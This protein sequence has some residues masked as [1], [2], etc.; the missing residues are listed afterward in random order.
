MKFFNPQPTK[1]SWAITLNEKTN[2]LEAVDSRKGTF[3]AQLIHF[4]KTGSIK[5]SRN[6]ASALITMGYD[7]EEH[8]NTFDNE[9][10]IIIHLK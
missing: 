6:A 5:I 1:K 8:G 4:D 7:P 2:H 3:I 9:G 10:R